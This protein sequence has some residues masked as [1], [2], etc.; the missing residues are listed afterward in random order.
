LRLG[1][2]RDIRNLI[3]ELVEDQLDLHPGQVRP[4]AGPRALRCEAIG[5]N[6]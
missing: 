2:F 4:D 6:A 3:G 5:V 1:Q